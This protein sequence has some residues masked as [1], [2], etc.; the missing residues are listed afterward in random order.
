MRRI[1]RFLLAVMVVGTPSCKRHPKT[2]A[3]Q[4]EPSAPAP[5]AQAAQTRGPHAALRPPKPRSVASA[6]PPKLPTLHAQL[7]PM[8]PAPRKANKDGLLG[9]YPCGSVW[10]G[11]EEVALECADPLDEKKFGAPAV[12]L[13]PYERLHRARADLPATVDHRLDG[14]EGRVRAQG[15]TRACTAFSMAS[16][17]DHAFGL[18]TGQPAETSVMQVWA[19]Y[20]Q[21]HSAG[22]IASSMGRTVA[23]ESDWPFDA[24]VAHAWEKCKRQGLCLSAEEQAR[25]AEVDKK[26]ILV[27]EQ[28]EWLPNNE[29]LFDAM[30]AKLAAGRDIGSGGLLHTPFHP[31]GEAGSR[32]IPDVKEKGKSGHAFSLVGYTHVEDERYFLLKNSWGERWGDKGYAWIHE[33]S[34][35]RMIRGGWVVVVDPVG[36]IALRRH[37]RHGGLSAACPAGEG[38]DSIDG[39]CQPLCPDGGPRHHDACGVTEDCLKGHVNL[40]GECVLSAPRAKGTEPKTGIAYTCAPSGCVYTLPKG[41]E[42][43][44]GAQCQKSCPAPDYR[45]GKGQGGLL[46]LE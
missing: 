45:L 24:A 38:P 29:L 30:E 17:L 1:G 8:R 33:V 43:C 34:L 15:G 18:W 16:Q 9:D 20:H 23:R 2:E 28:V 37:K 32:Y 21:G 41:V 10:T 4:E 27:L 12:A 42:G 5:S 35:R 25:L 46:C 31:V 6:P 7:P 36:E 44:A 22:A 26:G 19:R 14:F 40:A 11:E 39:T 13:I 3:K